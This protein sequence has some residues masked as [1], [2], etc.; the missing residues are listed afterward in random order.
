M[1]DFNRM[2]ENRKKQQ[3]I[4]PVEI[5]NRSPKPNGINDLYNS[6]REILNSWF[7][8][9]DNK[10]TVLQLHTGGG[11]T[12]IGLLIAKSSLIET[13]KPVLYLVPTKQLVTQTLEKAKQLDISAIEYKNGQDLSLEF[14]SSHSIMVA[15]YNALFNGK[16]RFGLKGHSDIQKIGTIIHDD[17]HATSSIIRDSFSVSIDSSSN[18]VLYRLL[19]D[20]FRN[21]FKSIDK[22]GTLEDVIDGKESIILDVPYWDWHENID[23]IRSIL[24]INDIKENITWPLLRDHLHL[25]H[26]LISKNSFTI[27]PYFPLIDMFP[28]YVE[29]ERK[30]LMSATFSD[31]SEII[32]NFNLG[33]L[34][35]IE[36]LTTTSTTGVSEKMILIP[37]LMNFDNNRQIEETLISYIDNEYSSGTL[38]LSPSNKK[39]KE[40]NKISEIPKSSQEVELFLEKLLT[41]NISKPLTLANRYDGIDLPGESCRLLV[42]DGLPSGSSSYDLYRASI[43]Y[44]GETLTRILAQRIEQGLGRGARG[45]SDY[46]VVLLLGKDL[47]SWLSNKDNFKFLTQSTKAQIDMG[48]EISKDTNIDNPNQLYKTITQSLERDPSWISFHADF[49]ADYTDSTVNDITANQLAI[50]ERNSFRLW[51]DKYF[52]QA[53][54]KIE[55]F[56]EKNADSIDNQMLGWLSQLM[57]RIAMDGNLVDKSSKEQA[58]AFQYNNNVLRPKS[59]PVYQVLKQPTNQA[60]V[61]IQHLEKY[62]NKKGIISKFDEITSQLSPSSSPNNFEESM[63]NFGKLIGFSS[64]RHDH[65]GNGPDILWLMPNETGILIE[66]K[67]RKTNGI[68]NKENH[69]QLLVANE[70][71]QK[72]YPDKNVIRLSVHS[73]IKATTNAHAE[74]TYSLTFDKLESLISD[75][76]KFLIALLDYTVDNKDLEIKCQYLLDESNIHCDRIIDSYFRRFVTD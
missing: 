22:I 38:I 34:D 64:E 2:K 32:R 1:V 10:E 40:W 47:S 58:N 24:Q 21:S 31:Y 6:Q 49:L 36:T 55:K 57:A 75:A 60:K 37:D 73:T 65:N 66:A 51:K 8:K 4:E 19:I 53:I 74:N 69:G 44:G 18:E 30:V 35:E 7:S 68:Y 72:H 14:K 12:L 42:L 43:L 54:S 15:T 16:S 46:C 52:A 59:E 3:V 48:F 25:C 41:Q 76:R 17:A 63:C 27:T 28:S 62:R 71:F 29:A 33:P 61:I 26:A 56:I 13:K 45:G 5:F 39:A 70:W 9:R 20:I 67:S 11:K 23:Q 50:V